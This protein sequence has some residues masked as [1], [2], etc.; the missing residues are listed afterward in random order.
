MIVTNFD[1][2]NYST[3]MILYFVINNKHNIILAE[4]AHFVAR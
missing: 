4:P 2:C 1:S 3:Y